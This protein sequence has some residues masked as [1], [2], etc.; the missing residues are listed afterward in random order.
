MEEI[1]LFHEQAILEKIRLQTSLS[2]PTKYPVMKV[3]SIFH[4]GNALR[5]LMAI[6]V[7][8]APKGIQRSNGTIAKSALI[9][10]QLLNKL[11]SELYGSLHL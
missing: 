2:A 5:D 1:S 9:L 3:I 8:H 11:F 4:L 10:K 7:V 6:Y